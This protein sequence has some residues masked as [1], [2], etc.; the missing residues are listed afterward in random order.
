[1]GFQLYFGNVWKTRRL[2]LFQFKKWLFLELFLGFPLPGC[3]IQTFL[4]LLLAFR[5]TVGKFRLP[6]I[7]FGWFVAWNISEPWMFL[8]SNNLIAISKVSGT[9][10][11]FRVNKYEASVF[12]FGLKL[13]LDLRQLNFVVNIYFHCSWTLSGIGLKF[14]LQKAREFRNSWFTKLSN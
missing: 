7:H 11:G 6:G 2:W 1:M 9:F 8:E 5:L 13:I 12:L 4:K 3:Q 10:L 14:G